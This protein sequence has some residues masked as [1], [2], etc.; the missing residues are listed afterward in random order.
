MRNKIRRIFTYFAT[1]GDRTNASNLKSNQF[2][3]MM[4]DLNIRDEKEL[5]KSKLD[6]LFVYEN[7]HMPNMDFETFLNLLAKIS[8]LKYE[9]IQP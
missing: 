6:L 2:H 9:N 4:I 3:K 1:F 7:K 5:T 8:I